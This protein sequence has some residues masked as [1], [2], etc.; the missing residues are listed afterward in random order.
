MPFEDVSE[1]DSLPSLPPFF[2]TSSLINPN[3]NLSPTTNL[4]HELKSCNQRF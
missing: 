4:I 2:V 1:P 3:L